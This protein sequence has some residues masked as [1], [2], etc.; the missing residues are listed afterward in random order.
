MSYGEDITFKPTSP[1]VEIFGQNPINYSR[2]GEF[3][4]YMKEKFNLTEEE[5]IN[6][7][8]KEYPESLI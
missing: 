8:K 4:K 5:F 6:L 3:Y 7:L 1:K 2:E